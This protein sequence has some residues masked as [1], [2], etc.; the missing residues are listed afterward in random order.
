MAYFSSP[1]Y[2]TSDRMG[3]L[4]CGSSCGCTQCRGGRLGERYFS[5]KDDLDGYGWYAQAPVGFRQCGIPSPPPTTQRCR[6]Q[7]DCPPV[8]DLL[9]VS[10]VDGIPLRGFSVRE[11]PATRLMV[12]NISTRPRTEQVTQAII[13]GVRRFATMMRRWGMD[14]DTILS[15]G[16]YN[17]RCISN[18]DTLSDH[19]W[20]DALDISGARWLG[21]APA[22]ARLPIAI[23][24]N[25]DRGERPILRRINAALRLSFPRVIDY[26]RTDH[27]DH[28]HVDNN[29]GRGFTARETNTIAFVQEALNL[30]QGTSL[31]EDGR[32]A[33]Q[34]E[35][36]LRVFSRLPANASL[37]GPV[38]LQ[39]ERSLFTF[40]A[41]AG[42]ER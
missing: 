32:L 6:T 4:G 11:D 10:A 39:C 25:W 17:C 9:C 15:M 7:H 3:G 22:G 27:R 8:P 28:F 29:R 34:T 35:Q 16:Y 31:R 26:H 33:P 21:A 2:P 13:D 1:S 18:T 24:H 23:A 42:R 37:A 20:G 30:A 14:F 12:A 40:V 36:A 19:S 41:S 38:L 5:D